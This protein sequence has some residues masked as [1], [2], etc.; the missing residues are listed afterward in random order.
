MSKLTIKQAVINV[1]NKM[2]PGEKLLGYQLYD[3]VIHELRM[4]GVTKR[5][6]DGTVL[7][8][9]RNVRD[10]CDMESFHSVSE[11][12]KKANNSP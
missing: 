11:Y 8:A 7:R 9:F 6:L 5:P 12:R 4:A 1:C 10:L 3:L 2:T